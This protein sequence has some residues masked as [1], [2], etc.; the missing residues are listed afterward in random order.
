[1]AVLMVI[2]SIRAIQAT[3][4]LHGGLAATTTGE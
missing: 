1:M 2:V 4:A 3:F